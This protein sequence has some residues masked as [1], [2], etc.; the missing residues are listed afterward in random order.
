MGDLRGV[1]CHRPGGVGD[2]LLDVAEAEVPV[3][4]DAV[5]G[6]APG[7]GIAVLGQRVGLQVQVAPGVLVAVLDQKAPHVGAVGAGLHVVGLQR[8]LLVEALEAEGVVLCLRA[9]GGA[10]VQLAV[11]VVVVGVVV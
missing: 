11:G 3:P 9:L 10:A 4:L 7:E 5:D 6:V 2:A 1:V 8:V